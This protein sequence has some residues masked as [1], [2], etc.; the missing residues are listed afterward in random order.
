MRR[1]VIATLVLGAAV[2]ACSKPATQADPTATPR[3]SP[4]LITRD[5]ITSTTMENAYDAIQRLRPAFLRPRSIAGTAQTANGSQA[6][7][8]AVV[9][10]DGLRKGGL[11]YLRAIP[12]REVAEVRYLNATDATT[13]Y[14]MNVPAGVIDVKL[15]GR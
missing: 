4:N 12:T 15:I 10:I 8:Y 6:Q 7:S 13:R 9:F 14:G 2:S 11:E 3:S 1:I 5:E